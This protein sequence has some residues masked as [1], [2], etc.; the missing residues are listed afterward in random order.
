MG[1]YEIIYWAIDGSGNNA[2]CN[3]T[4]SVM[5]GVIGGPTS[6]SASTTGPIAAGA[7]GGFLALLV[8]CLVVVFIVLRRRSQK[9]CPKATSSDFRAR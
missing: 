3:F 1:T 8:L 2:S 9:V 7:A 6:S 4:V 5:Q